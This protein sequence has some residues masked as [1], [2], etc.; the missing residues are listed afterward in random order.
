MAA[1]VSLVRLIQ[2]PK[3]LFSLILQVTVGVLSYGICALLWLWKSGRL[4]EMLNLA[5]AM[6]RGRR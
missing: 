6:F 5:K 4:T 2:T 1:C 3:A